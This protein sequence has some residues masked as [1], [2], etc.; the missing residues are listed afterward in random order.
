M[1]SRRKGEDFQRW[2][3]SC[4]APVF[5]ENAVGRKVAYSP[6]VDPPDVAA[7]GFHI[8]TQA[9]AKTDPKRVLTCA[10]AKAE[11]FK[12]VAVCKDDRGIAMATMRFDDWVDLVGEWAICHGLGPDDAA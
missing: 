7:P 6:D 4:L 1:Q 2:V 12:P 11:R 5:R 9:A 10:D 3:A 8:L